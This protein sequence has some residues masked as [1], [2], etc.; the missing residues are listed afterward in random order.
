MEAKEHRGCR[1]S[2]AAQLRAGKE[3]IVISRSAFAAEQ[4]IR[5]VPT[6]WTGGDAR[7]PTN[8]T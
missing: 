2:T 3:M 1:K 5:Q 8:Q 6:R 7:L 4:S